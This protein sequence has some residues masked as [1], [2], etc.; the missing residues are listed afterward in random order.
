MEL[1]YVHRYT[2]EDAQHVSEHHLESSI[3][4]CVIFIFFSLLL[5]NFFQRSVD[6]KPVFIHPKSFFLC[7]YTI[8]KSF[9][10]QDVN[11]A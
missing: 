4:G 1:R 6:V 9:V 11:R 10:R 7:C 8:R 3:L 2:A 5:S